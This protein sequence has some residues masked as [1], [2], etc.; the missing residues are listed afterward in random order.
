MAVVSGFAVSRYA[1]HIQRTRLIANTQ[2]ITQFFKYT[3]SSAH[4]LKTPLQ[5]SFTYNRNDEITQFTLKDVKGITGE[6][7]TLELENSIVTANV[8]AD[9]II[10]SPT[11]PIKILY[12]EFEIK[13]TGN[14][15]IQISSTK[16][17][18]SNLVIFYNSGAVQLVDNVESF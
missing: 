13:N 15:T 1:Y 4:S 12:N 10:F 18:R 3:Y 2:Q 14:I 5:V 11:A 9:S 16:K 8:L 7:Q 17:L 6:L